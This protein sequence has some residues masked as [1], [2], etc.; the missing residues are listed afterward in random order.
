MSGSGL[1]RRSFVRRASAHAS[2]L[3]YNAILPVQDVATATVKLQSN[4]T[5]G[6][7]NVQTEPKSVEYQKGRENVVPVK[8]LRRGLSEW[9]KSI[10]VHLG[11]G[12]CCGFT[13]YAETRHF[14]NFLHVC[15]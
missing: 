14:D 2:I 1:K 4:C 8:L 15:V 9:L 12:S 13:C 7:Q 6:I 3:R 5:H 11:P 10:R